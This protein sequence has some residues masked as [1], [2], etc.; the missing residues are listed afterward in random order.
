MSPQPRI[1]R[2][3][4][5]ELGHLDGGAACESSAAR[6]WRELFHAFIDAKG[7]KDED[8]IQAPNSKLQRNFKHQTSSSRPSKAQW[9]QGGRQNE[10]RCSVASV[11]SVAS[12]LTCSSRFGNL[13]LLEFGAWIFFLAS[14]KVPPEIRGF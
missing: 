10:D 12:W 6:D 4:F 7:A 14:G 11:A 1:E 5:S 2:N 13:W 3:G 9:S 8:K